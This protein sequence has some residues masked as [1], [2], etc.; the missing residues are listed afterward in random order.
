VYGNGGAGINAQNNYGNIINCIS[1]NN[2]TYGYRVNAGQIIMINCASYNNTLGRFQ[3]A[4]SG[5]QWTDLNPIT[6]SGSFFTNAAGG[7]FT[8][9]N[10][11]GAGA[12]CRAAGFPTSIPTSTS[13]ADY[14]DTGAL[15]SSAGGSGTTTAIYG[16]MGS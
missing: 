12:L 10:T 6:G 7:V 13:N 4:A 8:L 5:I 11:A 3:N 9:N 14:A 1:E 15:Q 2:T 16:V